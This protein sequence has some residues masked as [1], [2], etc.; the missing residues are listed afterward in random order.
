MVTAYLS[1]KYVDI[2]ALW[3]VALILSTDKLSCL[4]WCAADDG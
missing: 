4:N 2:L 1:N 3:H